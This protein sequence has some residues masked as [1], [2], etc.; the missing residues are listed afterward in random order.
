[1]ALC[2]KQGLAK[3]PK[4]ALASPCLCPSATFPR[5][6]WHFATSKAWPRVTLKQA[7]ASPC[8]SM[9]HFSSVRAAL[10]HKQALAKGHSEASIGQPSLVSKC[11]FS[12]VRVA[13]FHK[14]GLAKGR[15]EAS[16][17]QPV[18]V[19]KC[20]FSSVRRAL[21][22][23]QGP[24]NCPLKQALASPC[25]CES[26]TFPDLACVKVQALLTEEKWLLNTSKGWPRLASERPLASPCL[27]Q[28]AAPTEEKWHLDTS[29]GQT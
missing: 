12:S 21:C 17:G 18:L 7:L 22:H 1:M 10:C 23:K 14:Q 5:A 15:P 26:V 20:H 13:L 4:Q 28:S 24:A 19:S 9:R 6:G 25:L 11:H 27:W 29:K 2:H 3:G 8:S 16:L